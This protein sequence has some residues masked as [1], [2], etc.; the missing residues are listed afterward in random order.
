MLGQSKGLLKALVDKKTQEILGATLYSEDSHEVINLL[1]L[2][3]KARLPYTML[4][5]Q[6]FTHPTM[7]EALNDLF[8]AASEVVF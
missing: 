6:I 4:R 3:I 8:A 5:D 1:N 2:A 7:S